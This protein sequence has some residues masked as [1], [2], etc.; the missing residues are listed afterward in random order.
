MF[1]AS[2]VQLRKDVE[3]IKR[4]INVHETARGMFYAAIGDRD[5]WWEVRAAAPQRIE[6]QT[7]DHCAAFTRLY[8]IYSS[9]VEDLISQ[10]LRF[11]PVLYPSY[12]DLP[13]RVLR[14][15]RLGCAQILQKLGETGRYG[16]LTE[17]ELVKSLS[18]GVIGDWG[19]TLQRDA[20]FTERQNY[21]LEPLGR[22]LAFVGI[23]NGATR[24]SRHPNLLA[25]CEERQ[26]EATSVESELSRFVQIR[27]EAAHSQV[28]EIVS[29]E[30]FKEIADF[31]VI[32]CDSLAE[33]VQ[34][35]V[36]DRQMKHGR[37]PEI[38]TLT[39]TFKGGHVGILRAKASSLEVGDGLV[40]RNGLHQW[41]IVKIL[42]IQINDQPCESHNCSDGEEVGLR[43]DKTAKRGSVVF[44]V[45]TIVGS[46]LAESLQAEAAD[47]TSSVE[48]TD[49][50][51]DDSA[52]EGSV[53]D[54]E[55]TEAEA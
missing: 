17:H 45:T 14:Q 40:V 32:L 39:K 23:Q 51:A 22:L 47:Q 9:F 27:N 24:L 49:D 6:W 11:L 54:E 30:E 43:F 37:L 4:V 41:R 52:A 29:V 8:A 44:K 18:S 10:Y 53:I 26:P 42:S 34:I 31:I 2:L 16:H 55:G 20:F 5:L 1:S 35:E 28:D 33:I 46:S 48:G 36:V 25:F 7:Y 12:R 3:T 50:T 19:Y 38:G 21:R 13:D 15:H